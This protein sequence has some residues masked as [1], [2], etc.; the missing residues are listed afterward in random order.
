MMDS[1]VLLHLGGVWPRVGAV[2]LFAE[3]NKHELCF[4]HCSGRAAGCSLSLFGFHL[5]FLN[6][7]LS[8]SS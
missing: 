4:D 6:C 8:A 2:E 3:L 5:K 1:S 7:C